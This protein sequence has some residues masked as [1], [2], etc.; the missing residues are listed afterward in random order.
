MQTL[1]RTSSNE[2]L[3]LAVWVGVVRENSVSQVVRYP[4][5][6]E[7]LGKLERDYLIQLKEGAKPFAMNEWPSLPLSTDRFVELCKIN[8]DA[9]LFVSLGT[10]TIPAHHTVSSL[11]WVMTLQVSPSWPFLSQAA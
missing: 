9:N 6:F 2:A 3:D 4:S 1:P 8:A 10:T 7:G 5:P 11:T